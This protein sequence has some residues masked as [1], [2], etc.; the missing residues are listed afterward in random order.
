VQRACRGQ[1]HDS[2]AAAKVCSEQVLEKK[3]ERF[4]LK[5]EEQDELKRAHISGNMLTYAHVCYMRLR[6]RA[7]ICS[8]QK[9][10]VRSV[11]L[12]AIAYAD[13]CSRTLYAEKYERRRKYRS[14]AC[15]GLIHLIHSYAMTCESTDLLYAEKYERRR[16]YL[17][18]T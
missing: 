8:T 4:I 1:P 10:D 11:L 7:Q 18:D 9:S 3:N 6:A 5:Q 17:S 14:N 12:H 15:L 2:R 13:L 16:K